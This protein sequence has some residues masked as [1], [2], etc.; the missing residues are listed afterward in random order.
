M[1]IQEH[2]DDMMFMFEPQRQAREREI[3]QARKE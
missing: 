2:Q 1:R 3:E